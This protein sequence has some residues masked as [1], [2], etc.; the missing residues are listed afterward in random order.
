LVYLCQQKRVYFAPSIF[1]AKR[2]QITNLLILLGIFDQEKDGN[3]RPGVAFTT[4]IV[5]LKP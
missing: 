1:Y 5:P 3:E 2:R 4:L